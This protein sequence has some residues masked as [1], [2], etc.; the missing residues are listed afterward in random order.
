MTELL[1]GA[2]QRYADTHANA[3]GLVATPIEG[4]TL[5]RAYAPTGLMHAIY[6]PVLCLVL[7]G[8]KQLTVGNEVRVFSAGLSRISPSRST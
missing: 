2:I 8:A 3:D 5:M 1:K 6:K 7:R 4:V